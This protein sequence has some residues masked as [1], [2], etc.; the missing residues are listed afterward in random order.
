MALV[1]VY[2]GI[3]SAVDASIVGAPGRLTVA[4]VDDSG[5]LLEYCEINDDPAGY[6]AVTAMLAERFGGSTMIMLAVDSDDHLVVSLLAASARPIA[7]TDDETADDFADRFGDDESLDEL[8]ALVA[9]RR[10]VGLARALQAG[11]LSAAV[12]PTPREYAALKPILAAH[13]ALAIGRH[14]AAVALREVLRELYPAALRAYPDPAEPVALAMLDALPE[15]GLLSAA[16]GRG[17]DTAVTVAARLVADGVCDNDTALEAVTALRV[18]INETPRRNGAKQLTAA[19]SDAVRA[20]VAAVR[21]ADAAVGILIHAL[22]ERVVTTGAPAAPAPPRRRVNPAPLTTTVSAPRP[23]AP[24]PVAPIPVSPA[25]QPVHVP[26]PVPVAAAVAQPVPV[27]AGRPAWAQT[28]PPPT[29][30][31]FE[32]TPVT[33]TPMVP[34]QMPTAI[35]AQRVPAAP[36]LPLPPSDADLLTPF[37]PTLTHAAIN[38]ERAARGLPNK[39]VPEGTAALGSRANWPLVGEDSDEPV[40]AQPSAQRSNRVTPPWQADDLVLP[41]SLRLVE[42]TVDPSAPQVRL[43]DD[44]A[45]TSRI[46]KP[47]RTERNGSE[48]SDD[49]DLLIFA[50]VSS[51]W[52][53]GDVSDGETTWNSGMDMGWRTAEEAS[54][55]PSN[56]GDTN[57]GLPRRVPA[58]NLVPGSPL[59]PERPLRI[60]RDAGE[61][62]AHTS[63]YFRGWRRGNQEAG[64]FAVGGRPGRES[65]SGWDFSR[66]HEIRDDH[67]DYGQRAANYR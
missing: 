33:G 22:G 40:S 59:A 7:Y 35:P 5:R 32:P 8:Q 11:A 26:V 57:A 53:S 64:G 16:A 42:P 43:V 24:P 50:S 44:T 60:V 34:R 39:Q 31:G 65:A 52:F 55:R 36:P 63:N 10:A 18:A 37:V 21:S 25:P 28:T 9:G 14:A 12:T 23:V 6:A 17:R 29:P 46:P 2:C 1:R 47:R 67:N 56:G 54:L 58:A 20:S 41:P 45:L 30:P 49:T 48:M 62:A 38:D 19:V 4:V 3:S 27:A 13:S 66:E 15:P 51:A 61:I